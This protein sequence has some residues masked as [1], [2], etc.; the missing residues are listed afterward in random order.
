MDNLFVRTVIN[1]SISLDP[2]YMNEQINDHLLKKLKEKFEGKCLKHGYVQPGS[3]KILKRSIGSIMT[4]QFNGNMLYNI[5]FSVDLCNPME[6]AVIPAQVKNIN[7][8]GCLCGIPDED[9]SPLQILLAKQ[10]HIDNDEFNSLNV[11]D[12]ISCKIVG[13]RFEFGDNQISIIATLE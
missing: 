3:T 11:G 5:R 4:S 1:K 12:T 8:M 7:K 9:E 13:K 2:K 6:G 10:H